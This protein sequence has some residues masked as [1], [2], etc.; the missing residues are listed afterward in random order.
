MNRTSRSA[1]NEDKLV[2]SCVARVTDSLQNQLKEIV[3]E[4]LSAIKQEQ[5]LEIDSLKA[6]ISELKSSQEFL[7]SKYDDLNNEFKKLSE[8]NKKQR[9]DINTINKNSADLEK[10]SN[11]DSVKIDNI[12]QY[13][14]RQNL[15]FIGIPENDKEDVVDIVIKVSKALGVDLEKKD[16]STAHRLS[17]KRNN[18][19]EDKKNEPA[20]VI[21]RFVSRDVRNSIFK[22]RSNAR[23][24]SEFPITGMEKLYVNENLTKRRKRLLWKTKQSAKEAG[25]QYIWTWNGK[26]FARE[27]ETTSAIMINT[28]FDIEKL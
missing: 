6:E 10:Q 20:A 9:E 1:S 12:E 16:I 18:T 2:Q 23:K 19:G 25:Y 11:S 3:E 5:Q 28:E 17:A 21:A 4:A 7:C 8:V 26:I 22:R 27:N 13:E 24:L 15:E 14:R